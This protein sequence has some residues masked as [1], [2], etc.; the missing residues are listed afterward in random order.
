MPGIDGFETAALIR[1]R[2]RTRHIPII[3]LTAINTSE[4][5]IFQGYSVGALDYVVKPFEPEVLRAKVAAFIQIYR[6]TRKL[7]DEIAHRQKTEAE[8][9]ASN[10]LLETISRALMDF[11]AD[12]DQNRTFL[13]LMN[14][15]L[16]LTHSEIGFVSEILTNTQGEPTLRMF[17]AVESRKRRGRGNSKVWEDAGPNAL[18]LKRLC[19]V[20]KTERRPFIAGDPKTIAQRLGTSLAETSLHNF[21]ALP[22]LKADC[23]VGIVGIAN[24]V[25]GYDD[26]LVA[27]LT[28][29]CH[30]C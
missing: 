17:A 10:A 21:L 7:Q 3:F 26:A 23:L 14:S 24:R 18:A 2:E 20:I 12:G 9:D 30:T 15:L 8:L 1:A 16:T 25:G 19:S 6:N 5:H 4:T 22:L 29:F 27:S 28:P 13:N 11:I